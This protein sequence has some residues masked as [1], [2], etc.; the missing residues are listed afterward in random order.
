MARTAR[1]AAETYGHAWVPGPAEWWLIGFY[2]ALGV[3]AAFPRIRPPL[4]WRLALLGALDGGWICR[5]LVD[6]G[7]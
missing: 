6:R 3:F 1:R 7:P 5:P 2:A 4:R